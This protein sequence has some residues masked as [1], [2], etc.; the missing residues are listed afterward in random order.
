VIVLAVLYAAAALALAVSIR[1]VPAGIADETD[2]VRPAVL[3][4]RGEPYPETKYPLFPVFAHELVLRAVLAAGGGIE[5]L[6]AAHGLNA[7]IFMVSAILFYLL[8]LQWLDRWWAV[9]AAFL[10]VTSPAVFFAGAIVKTESFL[11]LEM[12]VVALAS[13]RIMEGRDSAAWHVAAAAGCAL[14]V[15]TKFYPFHFL[16]YF[17]AL[18]V[19]ERA[20]GGGGIGAAARGILTDRRV[21]LFAAAAAALVLLTWPVWMKIGLSPAKSARDIYFQEAP[22]HHRAVGEWTAFP[23]GRLSYGLLVV[24]P[25]AAGLV[26]YAGTAAALALRAVPGRALLMWGMPAAAYLA[27]IFGMTLVRSPWFF[28]MCVP[29]TALASALA[30][31]RLSG[32]LRFRGAAIF[33]AAMLAPLAAL[34][35]Y[36]SVSLTQFFINYY[37]IIRVQKTEHK[38]EIVLLVNSAMHSLEPGRIRESVEEKRPRFLLVFDS[39]L[40]NFCKFGHNPQYGRQCAYLRDLE[41]GRTEYRLVWR[42]TADYP[43]RTLN[44]DPESSSTFLLFERSGR[45][46]DGRY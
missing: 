4:I 13:R 10:Y 19:R 37:S 21:W 43:L 17:A 45:G 41:G 32:M 42:R 25:F 36:H 40:L 35:I 5:P 15:T 44:P 14:A 30:M 11:L 29:F 27:A 39:Y 7:A 16:I 8:C 2:I 22:T 24:M 33:K 38:G 26:N 31:K 9:F 34:S 18:A 46:P 6:A 3:H 28:T 20:A 23:Y 12:M 1:A